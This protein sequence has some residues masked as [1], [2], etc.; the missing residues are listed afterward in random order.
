MKS[1]PSMGVGTDE[2]LFF[3][4]GVAFDGIGM[5][6]VN[7]GNPP[8]IVIDSGIGKPYAVGAGRLHGFADSSLCAGLIA[9]KDAEKE[10]FVRALNARRADF[11]SVFGDVH[12]SC[13]QDG[14]VADT[15]AARSQYHGK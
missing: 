10:S 12:I 13:A 5:A 9:R 14:E 3:H 4:N 15:C 8:P 6:A 1:A 7:I 2:K 11:V